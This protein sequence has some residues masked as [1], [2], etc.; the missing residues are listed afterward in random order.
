MK[1]GLECIIIQ[2][3]FF[4]AVIFFDYIWRYKISVTVPFD[5]ETHL[6]CLY[7][8]DYKRHGIHVHTYHIYVFERKQYNEC[9]NSWK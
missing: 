3:L 1:Q 2:E 6:E 8:F 4:P 5:M 9:M 7:N